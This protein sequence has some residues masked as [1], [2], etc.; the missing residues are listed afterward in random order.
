MSAS[1]IIRQ[2]LLNEEGIV[3]KPS[4]NQAWPV[5]MGFMPDDDGV[6]NRVSIYDTTGLLDQRLLMGPQMERMAAQIKVRAVNYAVGWERI[7]LIT[8]ALDAVITG[9]VTVTDPELVGPENDTWMVYGVQRTAPPI[10]MGIEP[11]T[12]RRHFFSLNILV[13]ARDYS[14]QQIVFTDT[15]DRFYRFVNV[16][17]PQKLAGLPS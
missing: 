5:T 4:D 8:D 10:A 15:M 2:L 13:R 6:D 7:R 17:L 12:K 11:G 9:D 14:F 1:L 16:V 3:S